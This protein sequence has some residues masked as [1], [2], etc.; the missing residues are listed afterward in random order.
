MQ[1]E[2]GTTDEPTPDELCVHVE[3]GADMTGGFYFLAEEPPK[4]VGMCHDCITWC[5]DNFDPSFKTWNDHV[6][7]A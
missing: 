5:R 3:M 6:S 7:A 2:H 1:D 4:A